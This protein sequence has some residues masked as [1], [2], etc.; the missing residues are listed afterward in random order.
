MKK[1]TVLKVVYRD[2]ENKWK[3]ENAKM[4]LICRRFAF[5]TFGDGREEQIELCNLISVLEWEEVAK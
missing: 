3:S 1:N 2:S 5:V 4:V